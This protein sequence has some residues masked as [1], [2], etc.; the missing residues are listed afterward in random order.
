VEEKV[1]GGRYR[2]IRLLGRGGSA[3]VYLAGDSRLQK[4]WAVKKWKPGPGSKEQLV[5]EARYLSLLEHPALPD[6]ADCLEQKG[7]LYLVMEYVRGT[8]LE[9][10]LKEHGPCSGRQVCRWGQELCQVLGYLH[11]RTPQVLH[12]DLKPSNLIISPDGRLRLIDLGAA[13]SG[14]EEICWGTRGYAAPERLKGGKKGDVRSDIYSMGVTLYRLASGRMPGGRLPGLSGRLNDVLEKCMAADPEQRYSSCRE[15]EQALEKCREAGKGSAG[16][17]GIKRWAAAGLFLF[18]LL[19][20]AGSAAGREFEYTDLIRKAGTAMALPEKEKAL[21]DA[22]ALF[23]ERP[24]AIELAAEL[25][26]EDGRFEPEEEQAL[27][28]LLEAS[29]PSWRKTAEGQQVML[30]IG[31]LYWQCYTYGEEGKDNRPARVRSA[32]VW[33]EQAFEAGPATETGEAAENYIEEG[34]AYLEDIQPFGEEREQTGIK[35][36]K[37]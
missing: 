22:L 25:F 15:V 14:E 10:M 12:Q 1:I 18:L 37:G 36:E 24:E 27:L 26:R 23:P 20:R 33:F 16:R 13:G 19:G 9:Q 28:S 17:T 3:E 32:L 8:T 5:R 30:Q 4:Y 34:K 29:D 7:E 35:E 31:E 2:L 21:L 6:V 11:S